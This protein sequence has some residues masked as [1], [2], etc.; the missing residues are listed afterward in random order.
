MLC[1]SLKETQNWILRAKINEI[2][3][4]EKITYLLCEKLDTCHLFSDK[5]LKNY[6]SVSFF[7]T[8]F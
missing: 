5:G 6:I 1:L 8:E 4:E 2:P 3:L 7:L